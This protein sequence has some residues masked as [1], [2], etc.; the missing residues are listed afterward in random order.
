M[1]K[2]ISDKDFKLLLFMFL[3]V[4]IV[5]I[6]YWG[7]RPQLKAFNSMQEEIEEAEAEAELN[8]MKVMNMGF[9]SVMASDYEVKIKERRDEFY[10]IMK[11]S[12]VD[13][14]MTSLAAGSNLEIFDLRF[15]MPKKPTERMAYKYSELY[16][17]Q[18][19]QKAEYEA[20]LMA[21]LDTSSSGDEWEDLAEE[22][23]ADT[24]GKK[25][26]SK[27]KEDSGV[28]EQVTLD[29]FGEADGYRP[30]TD[31]Y[32]VPV[33]MTVG[34]S[35]ADLDR[36][37]NRLLSMDKRALVTGYSW[38]EYRYVVRRDAMGNIIPSTVDPEDGVV[39]KTMTV[40][41]ELYMCDTT[42]LES[43][44]PEQSTE[45]ASEGSSEVMKE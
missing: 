13:Q 34:G 35:K 26:E 21:D 40:R 39:R 14:M 25:K 18:L 24:K 5:G 15:S 28:E 20:K 7:I 41:I 9:V 36:F 23:E 8:D 11:S 45:T 44:V 42:N 6:G 17:R 32:A 30:N 19:Q 16:A 43:Q 22:A 33:T 2:N 1:L 37:I 38:G 4:V 31:I 29:I 27:S 12:E 10:P 3:V